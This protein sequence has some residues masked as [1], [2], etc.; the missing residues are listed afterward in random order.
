[1][2]QI[3]EKIAELIGAIIGDGCISYKPKIGQYFVEIVGT[4]LEEVDYFNYLSSILF[5]DLQLKCRIT[6]RER[7]LRLKVYSKSFIM[8]L[9]RDLKLVPNKE[10]CKNIFIP[11]QI[12]SNE[13]LLKSCI[14]GIA[15]TDGSLFLANK[16]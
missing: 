10:K 14:R 15:D 7:G 1:M 2:I 4:Q 16:G 12:I 8:F 13:I 9:V 5:N 11:H 6:K 3:N